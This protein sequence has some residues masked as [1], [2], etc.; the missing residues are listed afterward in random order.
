M[1]GFQWLRQLALILMSLTSVLALAEPQFVRF[2]ANVCHRPQDA[3][4]WGLTELQLSTLCESSHFI[5]TLLRRGDQKVVLVG[6]NHRTTAAGEIEAKNI[7]ELFS[8]R[9][10]EYAS[11][12]VLAHVTAIS[13]GNIEEFKQPSLI[14]WSMQSGLTISSYEMPR[15]NGSNGGREYW[16]MI[17][18]IQG[19]APSENWGHLK[20]FKK[21]VYE[22]FRAI[23]PAMPFIIKLEPENELYD[24]RIRTRATEMCKK[25]VPC[26]DAFVIDYRNAIMRESANEALQLFPAEKTLL[27]VVGHI[28]VPGLVRSFVCTDGF[29]HH[30]L[31]MKGHFTFEAL[32]ARN[33][34]NYAALTE[35]Y[36]YSPL[37]CAND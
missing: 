16:D 3:K 18:K 33:L 31:S 13:S 26:S 7:A 9:G 10:V 14:I 28:H 17:S 37:N 8:F 30:T 19:P 23:Y 2:D 1:F 20:F 24:T 32:K 12:Q 11:P 36:E 35:F 21:R 4:A 27:M 29:E 5:V 25:N 22:N 34:K 6:E 15:I